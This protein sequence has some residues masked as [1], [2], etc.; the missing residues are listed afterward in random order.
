[1][2]GIFSGNPP[3]PA[4]RACEPLCFRQVRFAPMQCFFSSLA[5]GN[6]RD[7]TH[8]LE[9]VRRSLQGTSY[10]VEVF[11]CTVMPQQT[12][13]NIK[14]CLLISRAIDCLLHIISIVGM[15]SLKHRLQ[16]WLNGLIVFE[17]LVGFLRP[18]DFSAGN[19]PAEAACVAY[20]LPLS[21]VGLTALQ[22]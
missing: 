3:G 17:Y 8:K 20:D 9:A 4:A 22:A 10:C 16:R 6:I 19:A 7:C 18:V 14:P 21:Q 11:H 13:F 2:F 15:N 1:M 5:L 12:I